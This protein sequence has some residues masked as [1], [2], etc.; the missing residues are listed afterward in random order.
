MTQ[1]GENNFFFSSYI[2][3]F[4]SGRLKEE[5]LSTHSLVTLNIIYL[6]FMRQES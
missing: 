6:S 2:H 1:T 4:V 5:F 3:I